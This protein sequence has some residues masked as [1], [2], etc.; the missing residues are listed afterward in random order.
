MPYADWMV[1][2]RIYDEKLRGM[3]REGK[4]HQLTSAIQT[5]AKLGMQTLSASIARLL[6]DGRITRAVAEEAQLG[7]CGTIDLHPPPP[8]PSA[9]AGPAF[10]GGSR[11]SLIGS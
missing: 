8:L 3:I 7:H 2:M 9:Q 11:R 4:V 5:G 10:G 6:A 1:G